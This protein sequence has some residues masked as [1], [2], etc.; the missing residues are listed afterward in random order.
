MIYTPNVVIRT[1]KQQECI[2]C[3]TNPSILFIYFSKVYYFTILLSF[4]SP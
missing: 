1:L 3:K 2:K 4:L